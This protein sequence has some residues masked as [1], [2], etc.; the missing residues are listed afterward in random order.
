[1][2]SLVN[3]EV[4]KFSRLVHV[5]RNMR[6]LD[7]REIFNLMT[8][9]DPFYLAHWAG[10]ADFKYVGTYDGEAVVAFGALEMWPKIWNIFMF[11]TDDFPKVALPAMKFMKR[12]LV[13]DVMAVGAHRAQCHSAEYHDEAHRFLE[14]MGAV[15]ESFMPKYGKDGSGYFTYVWLDENKILNH[16]SLED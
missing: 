5:A 2:T 13:P 14:R 12:H 4:A 7:R 15:R 3:F 1:M 16:R 9:D 6:E 8:I 11:A 10:Q